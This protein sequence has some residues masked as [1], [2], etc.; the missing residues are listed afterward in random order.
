MAVAEDHAADRRLG[1]AVAALVAI[2]VALAF[3]ADS[4]SIGL[5]VWLVL[6]VAAVLVVAAASAAV[7]RR[8]ERPAE[9]PRS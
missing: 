1:L 7:Q 3:L 2:E 8:A 4:N 6:A 9:R 5:V